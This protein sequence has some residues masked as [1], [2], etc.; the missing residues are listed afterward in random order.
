VI[1]AAWL[2]SSLLFRW[3]VASVAT[4]R[5]GPGVLAAFLV[6]T[7]YVYVS[8]ISFMACVQLDALLR[9]TRS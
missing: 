6:L 8:A 3:F 5:T 7:T 1:V 9:S 4:Y 2:A